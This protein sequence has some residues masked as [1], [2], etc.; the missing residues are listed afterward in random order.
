M[1]ETVKRLGLAEGPAVSPRP[2]VS[3]SSENFVQG[4]MAPGLTG[5]QDPRCGKA[6]N[7]KQ[8]RGS[9]GSLKGHPEVFHGLCQEGSFQYCLERILPGPSALN[10]LL[11]LKGKYFLYCF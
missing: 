1:G 5:A 6:E 9:F 4:S 8:Y 3:K 7:R 10:V 11:P 2:V